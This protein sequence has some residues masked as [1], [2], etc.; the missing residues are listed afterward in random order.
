[1]REVLSEVC[2]QLVG[3][4]HAGTT[5]LAERDLLVPVS[6]FVSRARAAAELGLMRRLPLVV[7]HGSEL[8]AAGEFITLNV[9]GKALIVV[10]QSDGTVT[11]LL[12]M[13]RH[14]GG[15]VEQRERGS[16]RY[17]TCQYHGWSYDR[18]G[19]ALKAVPFRECFEPIDAGAHGLVRLQ[20]EERH[21]FI[22]VNL[23]G[24]AGPP[25]SEYLGP[26]VDRALGAWDLQ[27]SVIV[28]AEQFA[29]RINWKLVMDGAIDTMH[30]QFLHPDGVGRLV[31]SNLGVFRQY[32]RHGQHFAARSRLVAM[33]KAG[34]AIE[35][36]WKYVGSNLVIYP[37]AMMIAAPDH[38]EFWT[39]WPTPDDPGA[40]SIQ[41]RFLARPEILDT[42][43]RARIQKS[44]DILVA[45]AQQED[46]PMERY[47]QE[48]STG[49]PHGTYRY[50]RNEVSCQHLHRQLNQDLGEY[51]GV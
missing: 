23:S 12:N 40:C 15:K 32:G 45:A 8:K 6:H 43:M 25:L 34:E 47:I 7:A 5:Q 11:T 3:H 50:G 28:L 16:N 35:A 51:S 17:F 42:A 20:T 21:G 44:W 14:R 26:E 2:A 41:L 13:C 9:L 46:W 38:V 4:V 19:G 30:P 48:N 37:N 18:D 29:V 36:G 39:V 10:R 24:E 1:M 27:R 49:T 22:F 33:V 31:A